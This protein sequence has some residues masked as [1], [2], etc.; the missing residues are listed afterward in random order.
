MTVWRLA[1]HALWVTGVLVSVGCGSSAA[2]ADASTSDDAYSFDDARGDIELPEAADAGP[3]CNTFAYLQ[4][5]AVNGD[6]GGDGTTCFAC[7]TGCYV[8]CNCVDPS[9]AG[10]GTCGTDGCCTFH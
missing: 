2:G 8:A 7:A 5:C 3:D 10:P 6:A 1:T 4:A 9:G